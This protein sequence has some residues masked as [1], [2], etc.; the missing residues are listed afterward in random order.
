MHLMRHVRPRLGDS[1]E[2]G[3]ATGDGKEAAHHRREISLP[4]GATVFTANWRRPLGF[5]EM[6]ETAFT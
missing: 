4:Y 6:R 1:E 3:G 5:S 2:Q